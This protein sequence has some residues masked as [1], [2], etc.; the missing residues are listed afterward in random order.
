MKKKILN[1]I[2]TIAM[3]LLMFMLPVFSTLDCSINSRRQEEVTAQTR[4]VSADNSMIDYESIFNEYDD[5]NLTQEGSLTTFEGNQTL[6]LDELELED[7]ELDDET[8]E[9]LQGE[10]VTIR[11]KYTFDYVTDKVTLTAVMVETTSEG[12]LNEII[13]DTIEGKA[14]IN[15]AGEID[16]ELDLDGETILLS[17]LQDL[18]VVDNC[19]WFKK[20]WKKVV[21][22][23]V[24]VVVVAAVASAVVATCGAGLGACIAAGA[25]AGGVTGAISGGLISYS[26]YGKLDWRWIV[27]G[28]VIGGVIGAVV[29]WGVGG[30]V[31]KTPT[32]KTNRL[33]KAAKNGDL[34]FSKTVNNYYVSGERPYCNSNQLVEEIMKSKNPIQDPRSATGLKWE[35]EGVMHTNGMKEPIKG[36]WELVVDT[37]TETVW[38][39]L[40]RT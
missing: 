38:H 25:I 29:G 3:A 19:G 30:A 15:E 8:L 17:E 1:A 28:A 35:V 7:E 39:L 32:A 12:E 23:V 2:S 4:T 27:G 6:K 11:Y 18:G 20:L 9:K 21:V 14:F 13:V 36:V 22:A 33:I 40:F 10:E 5:V 26:E 31:M 34:K 16:A 37:K 24:A